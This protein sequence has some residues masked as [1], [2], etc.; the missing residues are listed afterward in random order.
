[1]TNSKE[2]KSEK[3][4]INSLAYQD[5]LGDKEPSRPDCDIYMSCFRSWSSLDPNRHPSEIHH[6]DDYL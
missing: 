3:E 4:V 6:D 5:V 1:M 2:I